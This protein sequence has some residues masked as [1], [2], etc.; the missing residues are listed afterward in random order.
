MRR[1]LRVLLVVVVA[2][3][4]LL[5]FVLPGRSFLSQA[6]SL[7]TT[8]KQV[9]ALST[10]NAKLRAE[11]KRLQNDSVIEQIAR[12]DYGLQVPGQQAYTIIPSAPS[13]TTTVPRPAAG[14]GRN[15][16]RSVGAG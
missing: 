14:S 11:A 10:E 7:K 3:G 4:I 1:A 6:Q 9:N 8:E 13:T 15:R 12:E 16:G 5:L 2:A